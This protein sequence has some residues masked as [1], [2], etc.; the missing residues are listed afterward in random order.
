MKESASTG[1][2][3]FSDW[4]RSASGALSVSLGASRGR[5]S[6]RNTTVSDNSPAIRMPGSRPAMNRSPIEVSVITP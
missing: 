3:T 2:T 4:I 1:K 6:T 5:A